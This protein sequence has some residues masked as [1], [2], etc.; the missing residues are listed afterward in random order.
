VPFTKKEKAEQDA[1]KI[2]TVA[3]VGI[4]ASVGLF[5]AGIFRAVWPKK[6]PATGIA[7]A[8]ALTAAGLLITLDTIKDDAYV[9]VGDKI[10]R[11]NTVTFLLAKSDRAY[12]YE[13]ETGDM[14]EITDVIHKNNA[15]G[16]DQVD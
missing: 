5:F 2:T 10:A 11:A 14:V 8:N 3:G 9:T 7:Y 13:P 16:S 6:T 12:R 15:K 1:K 4:I